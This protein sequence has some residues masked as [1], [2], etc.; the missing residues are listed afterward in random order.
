MDMTAYTRTAFQRD[1][2]HC[3]GYRRQGTHRVHEAP[4]HLTPD[5]T[6]LSFGKRFAKEY[7]LHCRRWGCSICAKK[8]PIHFRSSPH[9][10]PH[11]PR[12]RTLADQRERREATQINPRLAHRTPSLFRLQHRARS[13][14]EGS[15]AGAQTLACM[16][17]PTQ[18]LRPRAPSPRNPPRCGRAAGAG[19]PPAAAAAARTQAGARGTPAAAP[20]RPARTSRSRGC[21]ARRSRAPPA[22]GCS[23]GFRRR[24]R[25]GGSRAWWLRNIPRGLVN[26]QKTLKH[27][28]T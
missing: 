14:Q 3:Q 11:Q 2:H 18:R 21:C 8:T 20:G 28:E 23:I 4:H 17:N 22:Q 15:R 13:V 16:R 12:P 7:T 24:R 10:C 19:G 6:Q 5:S 9:P 1:R 27:K 26:P 25:R